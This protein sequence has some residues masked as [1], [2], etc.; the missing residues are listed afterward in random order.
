MS[1]SIHLISQFADKELE[2]PIKKQKQVTFLEPEDKD[3]IND[4]IDPFEPD[5]DFKAE[6][7][8]NFSVDEDDTSIVD[9]AMAICPRCGIS[10]YRTDY[11]FSSGNKN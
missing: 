6:Q 7:K 4:I 11:E 8:E 10:L 5:K 3:F 1:N 2:K 9:K